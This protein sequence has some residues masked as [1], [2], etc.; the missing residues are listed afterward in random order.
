MTWVD[1]EEIGVRATGRPVPDGLV[2]ADGDWISRV[3]AND[4]AILHVHRRHA[5]AG[6]RHDERGVEPDV[7]WPRPDL[8]VPVRPALRTKSQ[9]PLADDPC[10]VARPL[11][12]PWQRRPPWLDDQ[13]CV[14]GQDSGV[15]A[16]PGILAGQERVA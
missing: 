5:I 14:A 11:E 8:A 13:R 6:R 2:I 3:E 1:L 16:A 7:D 4:A 12:N 10:R 9:V 15:L